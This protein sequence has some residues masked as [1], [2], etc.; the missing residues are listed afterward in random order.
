MFLT[1]PISPI[2]S[3]LP[4]G[5]ILIRGPQV[6]IHSNL[7]QRP[8]SRM[9]QPPPLLMLPGHQTEPL[10]FQKDASKFDVISAYKSFVND[11]DVG[12]RCCRATPR[13]TR[14]LYVDLN[15]CSSN[16]I[17]LRTNC[18][19]TKYVAGDGRQMPLTDSTLIYSSN[20]VRTYGGR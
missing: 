10:N 19:D 1:S 14:S 2:L 15:A 9:A 3:Y 6:A 4:Q 16:A 7:D 18:A 13:L 12:I 17:T 8:Y 20:Y 11:P 5:M